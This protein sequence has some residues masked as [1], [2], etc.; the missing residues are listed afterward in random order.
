MPEIL[1]ALLQDD[2]ISIENAPDAATALKLAR[3]KHFDLVLLDL[4]LPDINGF[5][6]LQQL[7]EPPK[8][9][10]CLSLF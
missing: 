8:P 5:D 9:N 10:R 4:G 2:N 7:R 3:E 6:V 1:A